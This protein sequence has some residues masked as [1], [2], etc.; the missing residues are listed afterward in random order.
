MYKFLLDKSFLLTF[1]HYCF[2]ICE[3]NITLVQREGGVGLL[4]IFDAVDKGKTFQMLRASRL[5]GAEQQTLFNL[6]Q[7]VKVIC[8]GRGGEGG[9]RPH[10]SLIL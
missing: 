3:L 4:R 2:I 7:C 10:P 6:A 1:E 5:R 9:R 8:G